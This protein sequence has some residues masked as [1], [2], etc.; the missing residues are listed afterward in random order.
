MENICRGGERPSGHLPGPRAAP[1]PTAEDRITARLS[2]LGQTRGLFLSGVRL[3]PDLGNPCEA[4]MEKATRNY[5]NGPASI[6]LARANC[7][8]M[9][10]WNQWVVY[11]KTM[12]LFAERLA[13]P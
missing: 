2:H 4:G 7:E 3:T 8:V 13:G 1:S 12:V 9:R 5:P 11:R 6:D 10:D